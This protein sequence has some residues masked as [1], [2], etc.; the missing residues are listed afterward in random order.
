MHEDDPDGCHRHVYFR[1]GAVFARVERATPD[2]R[3]L[4]VLRAAGPGERV[5]RIAGIDPGPQLL[6]HATTTARPELALQAIAAIEAQRIALDQVTENYWWVLHPRFVAGI[7][8][9][10]YTAAETS[11]R[12]LPTE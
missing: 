10:P 8:G 6:L 5:L 12:G 2:R 7:E 3:Q 11:A 4:S 9:P 1:P